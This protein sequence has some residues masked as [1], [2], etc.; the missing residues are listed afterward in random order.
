MNI[1]IVHNILVTLSN[2]L[3]VIQLASYGYSNEQLKPCLIDHKMLA[4]LGW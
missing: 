1:T 3:V 2:N 4:S